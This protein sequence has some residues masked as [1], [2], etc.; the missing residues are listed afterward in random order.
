M[1]SRVG[2]DTFA[3]ELGC[4]ERQ[5]ERAGSGYVLHHDIEMELLWHSRVR[6]GGTGVPRGE[7][8]RQAGRGIIGGDYSRVGAVDDHVMLT[9]DHD[10]ILAPLVPGLSSYTG[11]H[12]MPHQ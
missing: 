6:P 8:E 2:V 7:L 12:G 4:A 1:A 3:V 9:S 5:D 10:P 11:W